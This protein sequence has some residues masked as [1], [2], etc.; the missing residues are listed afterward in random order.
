VDESAYA[1][2]FGGKNEVGRPLGIHA[3]VLTRVT[4]MGGSCEMDD[5]VGTRSGPP[6]GVNVLEA[7]CYLLI[8]VFDRPLMNKTADPQALE[9]ERSD[10]PAADGARAAGD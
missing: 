3:F 4:S 9:G 6:Q 10:E 7:P 1:V 2:L 5:C 8:G